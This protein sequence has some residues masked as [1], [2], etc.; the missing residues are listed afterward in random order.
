MVLLSIEPQLSRYSSLNSG[1]ISKQASRKRIA[2]S[3][4]LFAETCKLYFMAYQRFTQDRRYR[5]NGTSVR[6]N[7]K[8]ALTGCLQDGD[9]PFLARNFHRN[10]GAGSLCRFSSVYV[11]G[12]QVATVI[13]GASGSRSGR[14]ATRGVPSHRHDLI[15]RPFGY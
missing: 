2:L 1:R 12:P 13:S 3:K 8:I 7:Q 10:V 15:A 9:V 4:S 11:K 5:Q 14:V 6:S